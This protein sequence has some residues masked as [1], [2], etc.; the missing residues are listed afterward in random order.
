M[1][2]G[3]I[4][5]VIENALIAYANVKID[6]TTIQS[7]GNVVVIIRTSNAD[8]TD[9]II[10]KEVEEELE[11]EYDTD[12]DVNVEENAGQNEGE[13]EGDWIFFPL[14]IL[15]S[16]CSFLCTFGCIAFFC[17]R[18]KDEFIG[19][20]AQ[21]AILEPDHSP[22]KVGNTLQLM[23]IQSESIAQK[24]NGTKDNVVAIEDDH[25]TEGANGDNEFVI[26]GDSENEDEMNATM[27]GPKNIDT[28][29]TEEFEVIGDDETTSGGDVVEGAVHSTPGETNQ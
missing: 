9:R 17:C 6:S 25:V 7:D 28:V 27:G 12:I 15:M 16:I 11:K 26:H 23:K 5:D 22:K 13:G 10:E 14:I 21:E 19:D 20:N 1:D 4:E 8:L 2:E 24:Q 18:Q 3:E 29:E